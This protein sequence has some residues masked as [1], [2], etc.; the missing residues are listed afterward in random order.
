MA[1]KDHRHNKK[2]DEV[3][4]VRILGKDVRGDLKLGSALTKI[5]GVSWA[6]SNAICKLMKLDKTRKLQTYK[7]D[8]LGQIEEFMKDLKVPSFMKNRQNDLDTGEDLHI[9]GNDLSLKHDFDLK[10]LKKI[11]SYKGVRHTANLPVRGQRTKSN[12]RRN[13]KP[14]V[15]AAKKKLKKA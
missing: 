12:F 8:E 6:I 9:S 14:S 5:D 13:R 10:R 11:R 1:E 2:E 3:V 15:A 4:L 7:K